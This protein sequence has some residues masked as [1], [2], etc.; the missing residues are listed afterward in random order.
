M[1]CRIFKI[2]KT[3]LPPGPKIQFLGIIQR[4]KILNLKAMC[5]P[6]FSIYLQYFKYGNNPNC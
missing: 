4:I 6:M 1:A 5:S 2:L 3:E